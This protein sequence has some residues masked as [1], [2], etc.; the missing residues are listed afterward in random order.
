MDLWINLF[1]TTFK[2]WN[3]W[4]TLNTIKYTNKYKNYQKKYLNDVPNIINKMILFIFRFDICDESRWTNKKPLK[5]QILTKKHCFSLFFTFHT[6]GIDSEL[7]LITVR[8]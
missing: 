4:N 2:K 8:N 3:T 6:T 1:I 5:I 7:G